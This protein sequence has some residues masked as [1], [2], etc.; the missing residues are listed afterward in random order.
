MYYDILYYTIL[1]YT[2]LY[3]TI[4]YY[5]I[6]YYTI[7]YY[8]ILCWTS[9]PSPEAPFWWIRGGPCS[10]MGSRKPGADEWVRQARREGRGAGFAGAGFPPVPAFEPH[11]SR[12]PATRRSRAAPPLARASRR[13]WEGGGRPGLLRPCAPTPIGM[14]RSTPQEPARFAVCGAYERL[15]QVNRPGLQLGSA[16]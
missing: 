6:L 9:L 8:T 5:T 11:A 3:Y 16:I 12:G 7:L 10:R 1:Y 15:E 2:V 14:R 13:Q 4:L